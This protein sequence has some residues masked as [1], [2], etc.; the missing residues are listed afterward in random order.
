M[1]HVEL[2]AAVKSER[3]VLLELYNS[4]GGKTVA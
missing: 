3:Y 4:L 1:Q 2:T